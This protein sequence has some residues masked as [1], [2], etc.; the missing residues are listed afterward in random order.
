MHARTHARTHAVRARTHLHHLLAACA[1]GQARH[2]R[3]CSSVAQYPH[4]TCMP[5][6]SAHFA[7]PPE[8]CLLRNDENR[9]RVSRRHPRGAPA[10]RE[11]LISLSDRTLPGTWLPP[12]LCASLVRP[13]AISRV[14]CATQHHSITPITASQHHNARRLCC[15]LCC[16]AAPGHMHAAAWH[17]VVATTGGSPVLQMSPEPGCVSCAM[18][19]LLPPPSRGHPRT[20]ALWQQC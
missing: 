16:A 14:H 17:G 4:R 7:K 13:P 18:V 20:R 9:N 19:H 8:P 1:Q 15:N 2:H 10:A 12:S 3:H 11:L 6:L 5:A